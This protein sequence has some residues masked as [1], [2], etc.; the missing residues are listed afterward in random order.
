MNCDITEIISNYNKQFYA[1]FIII[2]NHYGYKDIDDN[3]TLIIIDT[4]KN[5]ILS[6][7]EK[8]CKNKIHFDKYLKSKKYVIIGVYITRLDFGSIIKQ[9]KWNQCQA[10]FDDC[11]K[12]DRKINLSVI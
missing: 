12:L 1:G 10:Y 11:D 3:P 2:R 5:N 7:L 9:P 8:Y 4:D 6:T